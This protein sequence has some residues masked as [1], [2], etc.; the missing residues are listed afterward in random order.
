MKLENI[1]ILILRILGYKIEDINVKENIESS[2]NLAKKAHLLSV[3]ITEL[4]FDKFN[5]KRFILGI[6][7]LI[8]MI[9][10]FIVL[11][12]FYNN[13]SLYKLI[14]NEFMP[15]NLNAIVIAFIFVD[16]TVISV[17]IDMMMAEWNGQL[18]FLKIIYFIQENIK[19]K[20]GLTD[21]NFKKLVIW[22]KLIEVLILR[23]IGPLIILFINLI[24][25]LMAIRSLNV[26]LILL[27]P[28]FVHIIW[29][30]Y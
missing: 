24:Y 14:D 28:F 11:I 17:R 8:F 26:T 7:D 16:C 19:E 30:I 18:D 21:L 4:F 5:Y 29:L 9:I 1:Q 27:F 6:L 15:K 20:H 25:L 12:V 2:A 13:D 22:G 3:D 10:Y 23:T